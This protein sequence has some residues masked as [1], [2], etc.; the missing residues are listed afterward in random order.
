MYF[1][2]FTNSALKKKNNYKS[3]YFSSLS[4]FKFVTTAAQAKR[5][6]SLTVGKEGWK[7]FISSEGTYVKIKKVLIDIIQTKKQF[8]FH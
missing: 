4:L 8:I 7:A 1:S 5:T 2:F 3:L 6:V